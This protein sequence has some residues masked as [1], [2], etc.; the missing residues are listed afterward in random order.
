[1]VHGRPL[2]AVFFVCR[3]VSECALEPFDRRGL[4]LVPATGG[5]AHGFGKLDH[6]RA[7]ALKLVG[8]LRAKGLDPTA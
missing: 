5:P 2:V 3:R 8:G 4:R 7:I 1:M 6:E